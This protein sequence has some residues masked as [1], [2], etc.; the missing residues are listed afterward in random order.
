MLQE[1]AGAPVALSECRL[2]GAACCRFTAAPAGPA[3][4][5]AAGLENDPVAAS[6][7]ER[8]HPAYSPERASERV[9]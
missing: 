6:N 5:S 3:S 9:R 2:D 4:E 7:A 8:F 1:L